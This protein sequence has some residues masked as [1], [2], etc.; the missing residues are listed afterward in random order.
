MPKYQCRWAPSLGNLEDTHEKIWGTLPYTDDKTPTVFFGCYGLPD[1]YAIWRHK[2]ERHVLWAGSD[3]RHLRDNYWLEDG[4]GI[5]IDNKGMCEWLDKY[6][7]N[8]CE[9]EVEWHALK[10]LGI[11]SK[12]CPSFL[13]NVNDYK[14]SFKQ[15]NKVYASVSGDNFELYGWDKIERLAPEYPQITFHLYG[16]TGEWK[17][18]HK[19]VIVHGRVPKE[20]MNAEIKEMQGGLRLVEF[21][22]FSEIL[23]KSILWGQYPVSLIRYPYMLSLKDLAT[24]PDKSVPNLEGRDYYLKTI[25][26]Y[27]WVEKL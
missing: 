11:K 20:V 14:V 4:G 10:E 13:G 18:E 22:G 9:N 12:I 8:W 21:D 6:C 23:A 25:N 16:N 2:G 3:I 5:R 1:F 15:G 17:T 19:N 26:N 7:M 27:P 24:L